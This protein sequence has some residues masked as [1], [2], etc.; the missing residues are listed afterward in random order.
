MP[1]NKC[2][3][4]GN[5]VEKDCWRINK[6]TRYTKK[7]ISDLIPKSKPGKETLHRWTLTQDEN[8]YI[9]QERG[10]SPADV[11]GRILTMFENNQYDFFKVYML[12]DPTQKVSIETVN[13]IF[14][15]VL[16]SIQN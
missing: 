1:Q 9:I 13:K 10:Y 4:G 14:H 12:N 11:V 16:P 3:C 15:Q 5:H 2:R 7:H 8:T 6:K